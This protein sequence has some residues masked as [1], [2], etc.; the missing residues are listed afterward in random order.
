[1]GEYSKS[2]IK[3]MLKHGMKQ[4]EIARKT[5]FTKSW[6]CQINKEFEQEQK[7]LEQP[8]YIEYMDHAVLDGP[9]M[10]EKINIAEPPKMAAIGF[11]EKETDEAICIKQVWSLTTGAHFRSNII[12]KSNITRMARF[13]Q[14]EEITP[15]AELEA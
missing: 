10:H 5:G 15:P 9:N 13:T 2:D 6:I 8:V 1:M 12:V 11:I 3:H 14:L 7:Q 4:I